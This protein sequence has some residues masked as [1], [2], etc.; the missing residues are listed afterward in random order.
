MAVLLPRHA[1]KPFISPVNNGQ[2]TIN[3]NIVRD[4][5]NLIRSAF[6]AHDAD[7][8][9]HNQ[10]GLMSERPATAPEGTVWVSTDT[11]DTYC[12]IGS[13][14]EQIGWAH[15]Y[16][17]FYDTTDQAATTINTG[18]VVTFDTTAVT[19]GV[20]VQNNTEITA[21]Y[22][23]MYNAQFRVQLFNTDSQEADVWLWLKKNG[24]NVA[25]SGGRITV[26]PEH[27]SV[28]GH[29]I[30]G[31][32]NFVQLDVGDYLELYWETTALTT[33]LETIAAA[34]DHPASPSVIFTLDRV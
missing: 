29:L 33:T 15:W 21:A 34:G 23:G 2:G 31:W 1:V 9:I 32:N 25:D 19:R 6:V 16:G 10:S 14:W 20:T 17:C 8:A 4:N 18:T 5:D 12:Y 28:N 13:Q 30:A 27:S 11:F 3:S 7:A 24:T 22:A 26:P